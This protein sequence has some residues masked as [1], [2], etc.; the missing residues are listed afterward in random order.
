MNA[1]TLFTVQIPGHDITARYEP[2][3]DYTD[4]KEPFC[5]IAEYLGWKHWVWTFPK[6]QDFD[7]DWLVMEKIL[8]GNLW[9]LSVPESEIR[10][11]AMDLQCENQRPVEEWL[12]SEPETIRRMG[13]IPQGLVKTPIRLEWAKKVEPAKEVLTNTGAPDRA[14]AGKWWETN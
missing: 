11:C 14:P 6:L 9:E 7:N 2:R 8:K 12:Y 5:G 1:I 4:R 3:E 13:D 10:W